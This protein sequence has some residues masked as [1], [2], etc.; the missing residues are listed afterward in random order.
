M[1]DADGFGLLVRT[2]ERSEGV[3]I[4]G[5][6]TR[7]VVEGSTKTREASSNFGNRD[8]DGLSIF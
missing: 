8:G 7:S 1:R 5:P 2:P 6:G 3:L 4:L